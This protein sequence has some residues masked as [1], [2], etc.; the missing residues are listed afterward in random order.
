M[1]RASSGDEELV[2]KSRQRAATRRL[3]PRATKAPSLPS[4]APNP[5]AE[6]GLHP[7][8][9]LEG[10]T[11]QVVRFGLTDQPNNPWRGGVKMEAFYCGIDLHS[12]N[13]VVVVMDA[14]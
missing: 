6:R 11:P 9:H 8:D 10:L 14:Q 12:N 4:Q 5:T 1:T 3:K 2:S 7:E 13:S